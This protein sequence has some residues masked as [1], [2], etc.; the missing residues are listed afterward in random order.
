MRV[1]ENTKNFDPRATQTRRGK[2]DFVACGGFRFNNSCYSTLILRKYAVFA[3]ARVLASYDNEGVGCPALSILS[4]FRPIIETSRPRSGDPIWSR[5]KFSNGQNDF[6]AFLNPK[7]T[8]S[9]TLTLKTVKMF[10]VLVFLSQIKKKK[11]PRYSA[12]YESQR[13]GQLLACYSNN[14]KKSN[15]F[16]PC[17]SKA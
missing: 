13:I 7:M 1:R 15:F 11:K 3:L 6:A 12:R 14:P 17:R 10:K 9:V 4:P 8:E 16:P 5:K 2:L